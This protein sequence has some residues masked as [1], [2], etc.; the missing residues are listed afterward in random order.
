MN[1][2]NTVIFQFRISQV[3]NTAKPLKEKIP[4]L[5]ERIPNGN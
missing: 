5:T 4:D 2:M 1:I 3:L